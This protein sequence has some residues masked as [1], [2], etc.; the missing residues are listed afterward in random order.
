MYP[1]LAVKPTI[2]TL[3]KDNGSQKAPGSVAALGS[4]PT[5]CSAKSNEIFGLH[6]AFTQE[7]A[8]EL[9]DDV[10]AT[11]NGN[12]SAIATSTRSQPAITSTPCTAKCVFA[13]DERQRLVSQ[14]QKELAATAEAEIS[15]SS[16][17]LVGMGALDVSDDEKDVEATVTHD[18]G[19]DT[20]AHDYGHN[21][22]DC[23]V[24]PACLA[25]N[26]RSKV[27]EARQGGAPKAGVL[28]LNFFD[29]VTRE[30]NALAQEPEF[31]D[32]EMTL[33]TGATVHAADRADLPCHLVG[34][35]P[36]SLAR[37]QFQAAGGKLIAIE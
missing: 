7:E 24:S 30:I 2:R 17:E 14:A 26:E 36:G 1:I 23:N 21:T 9:Y 32:V 8:D 34:E 31:I 25:P 6:R 15:D 28:S 37:Q 11:M 4:L 18:H 33:G 13:E 3:R 19:H 5:S 22:T 35:S 12:A 27:A 29:S 20:T 16:D 10:R